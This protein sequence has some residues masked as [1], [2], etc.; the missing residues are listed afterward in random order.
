MDAAAA[1]EST[2][3]AQAQ[4]QRF[5]HEASQLDKYERSEKLGEGTYGVV[6]KCKN[7]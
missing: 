6:Y 1:T 7:K 4:P 5:V 3:A 2:S